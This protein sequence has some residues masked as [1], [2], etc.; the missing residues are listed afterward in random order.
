[1]LSYFAWW[2]F[3][4]QEAHEESTGTSLDESECQMQ[5]AEHLSKA[6][7]VFLLNQLFDGCQ[8]RPLLEPLAG[9]LLRRRLPL[10]LLG[11]L[12]SPP[13]PM[14]FSLE[15]ESSDQVGL[16]AND[17]AGGSSSSKSTAG[18]SAVEKLSRKDGEE[19]GP[20]NASIHSELLRLLTGSSG[21]SC[22][23]LVAG[24]MRACLA[25]S[26]IISQD[27][28]EE[29]GLMPPASVSDQ[30]SSIV[31]MC[32]PYN[33]ERLDAE[34]SLE[35][36]LSAAQ[37]LE[38][39]ASLRIVVIQ[40]L[41]RLCLDL[42]LAPQALSL[43]A[44]SWRSTTLSAV[45]SAMRSAAHQVRKYLHGTLTNSF[46]DIFAEE[47]ER[48]S[49]IP[50]SQALRE[51]CSSKYGLLPA[52]GQGSGPG[53]PPLVWALPAADSERHL[54]SKAVR[55]LLIFRHLHKD[56]CRKPPGPESCSSALPPAAPSSGGIVASAVNSGEPREEWSPLGIP[57]EVADGYAEGKDLKLGR[58]DRIVCGVVTPE[59]RHTRYLVLHQFVLLLAQP[60]IIKKPGWAV[61][62]TLVALRHVDAQIDHAEPRMLRIFLR[63]PKG[64][65][66]PGEASVH[67][68]EHSE[69]SSCF[70]LNLC[71]EDQRRCL[72]AEAHLKR[73]T[74]EIRHR[75][76]KNVEAFID[77]LCSQDSA[78]DG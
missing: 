13:P 35:V 8:S 14:E 73:R 29:G 1:M 15:A 75:L 30:S 62:R 18:P 32:S 59:G 12:R 67:D 50:S 11:R 71:F 56:L 47:W 34:G 66:C 23:L 31:Q 69:S 64:A 72:S 77:G 44:C 16:E 40:G 48:D 65:Q 25:C 78:G 17:T 19:L 63:L 51:S 28:L 37:T 42:A 54:A 21:D 38:D 41:C 24:L 33:S 22:V 52:L 43:G 39:H 58:Q 76:T 7:A 27:L 74:Q 45:K 26:R 60:D 2:P 61:A 46:L 5:P 9:A 68:S 36:L 49:S 10:G 55:S 57:E 20:S 6:C 3:P 70:V 4:V 53:V